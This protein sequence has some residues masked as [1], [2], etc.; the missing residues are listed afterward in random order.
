MYPSYNNATWHVNN[1]PRVTLLT[2][3]SGFFRATTPSLRLAIMNV[4]K[5][6]TRYFNIIITP[7]SL[8]SPPQGYAMMTYLSDFREFEDYDTAD[9]LR[10]GE[11]WFQNSS[12]LTVIKDGYYNFDEVLDVQINAD[13]PHREVMLFTFNQRRF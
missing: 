4:F 1:T 11:A 2:D 7:T 9:L 8:W 3:V 6:W 5:D 10:V 13:I 12:L